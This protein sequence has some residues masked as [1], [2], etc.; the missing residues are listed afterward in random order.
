MIDID[1]FTEEMDKL[2]EEV[3]EIFYTDLNGGI[4]ILPDLKVSPDA[5]AN[6][7]FVLGMYRRSASMGRY[8]EIYYGSFKRM[9]SYL[10]KEALIEE[11][12]EVLFHEFTH[13]IESLAGERGLEKKDE[14]QL[15]EYL[16]HHLKQDK[17]KRR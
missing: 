5:K 4:L 13:H 11:M 6:D 3:P 12:R 8:I 9:F 1:E 17:G 16:A 10:S 14:E 7:L 15:K 2:T